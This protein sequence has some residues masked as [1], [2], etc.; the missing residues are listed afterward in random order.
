MH[1]LFVGVSIGGCWNGEHNE[2][3]FHLT[4]HILCVEFE[5]SQC[6]FLDVPRCH[7]YF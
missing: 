1:S 7:F 4:H 3:W 2:I 5:L 6:F